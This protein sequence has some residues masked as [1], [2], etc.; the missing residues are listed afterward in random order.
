VEGLGTEYYV[1]VMLKG[2]Q[3]F[4]CDWYVRTEDGKG[5]VKGL[6]E[7]TFSGTAP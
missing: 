2:P 6:C 1:R 3:S 7:V 5:G 4:E